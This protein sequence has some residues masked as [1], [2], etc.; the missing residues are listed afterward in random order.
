MKRNLPLAIVLVLGIIMII[1]F[2]IPSK[3]SQFLYNNGIEWDIVIGLPAIII[4]TDSLVRH[5][6]IKI[7]QRKKEWPFSLVYLGSALLMAVFGFIHQLGGVREGG[8]F[9]NLFTYALAPM[10]S[11]VFA[12]L[13]F[14]MTS[15]AYRSFRARTPEA[16][17]LLSAAFIV[18]LGLLPIGA[19][20]WKGLP[21]VTEWLMIVP[22]MASKRGITF[23][24]GLGMAAT[25][26]K[27]I[28]G[29]ERNWMGGGA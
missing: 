2:F 10:Q 27:I 12:L 17:L 15:A 1:Q 4:A 18:M 29:I 5:H 21:W 16:T 28:L 6:V 3:P 25:C 24:I 26:V 13:A 23:G 8:L 14:Y 9:M 19:A 7:R 20:I 11:T 22:N